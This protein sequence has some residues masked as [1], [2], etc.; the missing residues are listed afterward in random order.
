MK[1]TFII[2]LLFI[3]AVP[4]FA[5]FSGKSHDKGLLYLRMTNYGTFG[6]E[7]QGIWPKGTNEHYIFGAGVW[8]GGLHKSST[9]TTSLTNACTAI[10]TEILVYS[11]VGFD[12]AGLLLLENELVLYHN[13]T[14]TSF[15]ELIRGFAQTEAIGHS[16]NTQVTEMDVKV[17]VGYDASS[18][19]S[20]FAPGDLPNEPGYTNPDERVLMTDDPQDT[21][22]WPL[23][24]SLNNPIIRSKQD[25]YAIFNDQDSSRCPH[26]LLI[27]IIQIGYAWDYH[28]YEDFIF[29]NYLVVNDSPDTIFNT[30][31]AVNCDADI[32]DAND[33]LIDFNESRDLGYAYDSDFNEPGWIHTPGFM[34]FDFLESPQD[35][36]GQQIGLTAFKITHNPGVGGQG[37]P[38]PGS[39]FEAYQLIAGYNYTTGL[40]HPFDTITAPTDVRFLQ[41]T[42]PF[43]FAPGETA[44]VVIAVIA[45]ADTADF[46]GNDVLAQNLYDSGYLTH[47]VTVQTPNGGEEISGTY[48]IEWTDSSSTG[49]PLLVDISCSRDGG[50]TFQDIVTS[51]PDNHY[52]DWNTTG[53]ADG[54][55]YTMRVTVHDTVAVG[56][57]FSDSVFTVN[58]PGNGVPD[59]ILL[60]PL[61]GT[62]RDTVQ[63]TW[64]A[65]DADD[66]TLSI[67]LFAKM[68]EGEWDTIVVDLPN[69]GAYD[70]KTFY[71][72]N[73]TY[74]LMVAARDNDT[75]AVDS[76]LTS[77]TIINDHPPAADVEHVQGGCN[78]LTLNCFSYNPDQ[79]TGHTYEVSFYPIEKGAS[80]HDVYYAY[81]LCDTTMGI[82]LIQHCSLGVYLDG[83][84]CRDYSPIIDG[85]ALEF[86]IQ[87]DENSFRFIDFD[88][89][90]N[91]SGFDGDLEIEN[92]DSLGTAPPV[93]GVEWPFR[94][95]DYVVRWKKYPAD[96]TKLTIEVYDTTNVTSIP[97][98]S[99][100]ID[101][102]RFEPGAPSETYNP[103]VHKRFY[104]CGGIFWFDEDGTMTIPP[105][106]GDVW[107]IRS[108]GHRVPCNNNIYR[109]TATG[110]NENTSQP[111]RPLFSV[112][113]NIF[114]T[115][116]SIS[117][118]ITSESPV[119]ISVYNIL[120]Q[121]VAVVLD[122]I[123]SPGVYNIPW[124]GKNLPSGIYFVKI[125]N[126]D[127]EKVEKTI[128]LK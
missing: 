126:K 17:S 27:K 60:S 28:Y 4:G 5:I 18:G 76:S 110:I 61:S 69:T 81:N 113:P 37:E 64:W 109:F 55:R 63:I 16:Q 74:R 33:D 23:R 114:R 75:C 15:N 46:W 56:E 97:Y 12:S 54:T 42:G 82:C 35:T 26:P 59:V 41:C 20:E 118:A 103:S 65:D 100:R 99:Q 32:G 66:D 72:H 19:Q 77:V 117:F 91:Q 38:D 44:K 43:D 62:L 115:R 29:I 71:F 68:G 95:S 79:L 116:T 70:W 31:L 124:T 8:V 39:N 107:Q 89:V 123:C 87:I 94:A 10:D 13:K 119:T 45:G 2:M 40:Y 1:R 93:M 120:G 106:D 22:L 108:S 21:S 85:F 102:W 50:A 7:N 51:I 80:P 73:G 127:I 58:N 36:L 48:R 92:E 24:D 86:N 3:F 112:L 101:S 6:Y 52:Y 96:T 104:L 9:D 121:R 53:Y 90:E 47:D 57:D 30:H 11:T 14:D 34:G 125:K 49:A 83:R 67:D 98:N 105:D 78:S 128:Y 122:R 111:L 88:I 84:L 25:S